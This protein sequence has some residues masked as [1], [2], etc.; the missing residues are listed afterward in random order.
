MAIENL[1]TFTEVDTNSR[2]A[3]TSSR[4]TFTNITD[5]TGEPWTY[6]MK[7]KGADYFNGDF[8]FYIDIEMADRQNTNPA[9]DICRLGNDLED[10]I[11]AYNNSH[12][13]LMG[14]IYGNF[15]SILELYGGTEYGNVDSFNYNP[16]G[17]ITH[18]YMKLWRDESVGTYGTYY[19]KLFLTA[20]DRIAD[21]NPVLTAASATQL[22]STL[23]AN[24]DFRYL[25]V[26]GNQL[27]G[28]AP[29]ALNG[30]FENLDIGENNLIGPMP[31][32]LRT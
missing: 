8:T 10:Y 13:C 16:G 14:Y 27:R 32:F 19:C 18:Y 1:T 23:H 6:L 25:W 31:S 21:T 2:L 5:E 15:F 11:A 30:Y 24:V 22:T 26:I 29:L 3:I 17:V 28:S 7:D 20:A 9:I 4:V 12:S